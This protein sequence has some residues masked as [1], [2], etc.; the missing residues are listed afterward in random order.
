MSDWS[1]KSFYACLSDYWKRLSSVVVGVL[2]GGGASFPWEER[3]YLAWFCYLRGKGLTPL[4]TLC[5]VKCTVILLGRQCAVKLGKRVLKKLVWYSFC[6]SVLK[7]SLRKLTL[8]WHVYLFI[9]TFLKYHHQHV[10][11]AGRH[12]SW[13]DKRW[14]CQRRL[15]LI[16]GNI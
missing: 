3:W 11:L 5:D 8:A 9:Y 1:R 7:R 16:M 2:C 4:L 10:A 13:H 6:R 14:L 15:R 12:E